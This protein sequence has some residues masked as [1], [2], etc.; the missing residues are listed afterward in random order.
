MMKPAKWRVWF[1]LA[2]V[3]QIE[4][5]EAYGEEQ[6]ETILKRHYAGQLVFVEKWKKVQHDVKSANYKPPISGDDHIRRNSKNLQQIQNRSRDY[7]D[8]SAAPRS[9]K[10]NGRSNK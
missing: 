8:I 2:G 9:A 6:I 10:A 7:R 4:I 1:L 5:V 3:S